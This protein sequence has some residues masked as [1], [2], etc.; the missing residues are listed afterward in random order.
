M[1]ETPMPRDGHDDRLRR[2]ARFCCFTDAE[3]SQT[4]GIL[5][6]AA[7]EAART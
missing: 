4:S 1:G 3:C 2:T 5:R 6:E 7:A